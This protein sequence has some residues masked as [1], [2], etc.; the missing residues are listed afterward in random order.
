MLLINIIEKKEDN[1]FI[2][3]YIVK[4]FVLNIMNFFDA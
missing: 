3:I 1:V 2:L 4:D